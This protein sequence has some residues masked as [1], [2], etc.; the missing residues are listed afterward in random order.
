MESIFIEIDRH[1]FQTPSNIVIG[2]IYRM[3]DASV[4][5]FNER[6]TDILTIID[7]EKKIIDLNGDLNIDLFKCESHKPTCTVLDILY[8]HSVFLW[9]QNQQ[10]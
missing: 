5:I 10:E 6:I 7:K 4:D 8:S 9:L 2:L 3:P 1:M